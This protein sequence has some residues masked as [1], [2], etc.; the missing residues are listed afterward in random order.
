VAAKYPFARFS[1][2]AKRSLVLAQQEAEDAFSGYIG[3][4]HLL[5]GIVRLGSGSGYRALTSLGIEAGAV[6]ANIR[7]AVGGAKQ[8]QVEQV[9]PTSRTKRVIEI[10]FEE[11][12]RMGKHEVQT[13]HLLM[14]IAIEGEGI[15]AL[16]LQDLGASA[17]RVAWA[18]EHDVSATPTP[19]GKV[20]KSRWAGLLRW[21]R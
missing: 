12:K 7:S 8:V 5:L 17:D 4:E 18:V 1:E 13:G 9:I 10:A 6:R 3:T 19:R 11:S 16:V 2:D 21:R 20:A 15:G 14:G